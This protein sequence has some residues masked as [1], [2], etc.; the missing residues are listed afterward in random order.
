[1]ENKS[2]VIAK[3]EE[4]KIGASDLAKLLEASDRSKEGA[5]NSTVLVVSTADDSNVV[6]LLQE[7]EGEVFFTQWNFSHNCSRRMLESWKTKFL[8]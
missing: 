8:N 1:V 4:F 7:T 5:N 2:F 3:G 6:R